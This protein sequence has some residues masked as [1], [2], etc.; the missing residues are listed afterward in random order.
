MSTKSRSICPVCH[1]VFV[2]ET[3]GQKYCYGCT[4]NEE[5]RQFSLS[6]PH[7]KIKTCPSCGKEFKTIDKKKYCSDVCSTFVKRG[8]PPSKENKKTSIEEANDKWVK[9]VPKDNK[10]NRVCFE[11]LIRRDEYKRV[12]GK[13]SWN[14]YL[15]G[16]KWNKI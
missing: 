6:C 2:K 10:G 14:H 15:K 16:R 3:Y 4:K 11:E 13:N 1:R 7:G 12:F 8:R 5:Y 9:R